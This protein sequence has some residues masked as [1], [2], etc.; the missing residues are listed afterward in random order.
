MQ[1]IGSL[2]IWLALALYI[3]GP[4]DKIAVYCPLFCLP[5]YF[6]QKSCEG[7]FIKNV[8]EGTAFLTES[9]K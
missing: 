8:P 1:R 9:L 5:M 3:C 2:E 4:E 7:V 6:L